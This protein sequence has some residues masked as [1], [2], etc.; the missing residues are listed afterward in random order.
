MI[1]E[2]L[3]E[4]DDAY[5]E[6]IEILKAEAP[7]LPYGAVVVDEAQDMGEQAFRLIRAIVPEKTGGDRNSIFI[8]GDAHQHIYG[9]RAT[10]TACGINVRGRSRQLRLNY[11]TSDEIRKWAVS[12]L[13]GVPVDDLDEG[14]DSLKRYT[15]AHS[16]ALRRSSRASPARRKRSAHWSNGFSPS[17]HEEPYWATF[18][19]L[20]RTTGQIDGVARKLADAGLESIKLRTEHVR[21]PPATGRAAVDHALRAG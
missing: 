15:S 3:A 2:G 9:R 17:R 12:V 18:G 20:L 4:P 10:M 19:V 8:V 1:D 16:A 11:R 14:A 6:A 13:E 5:R 21:R 7:S